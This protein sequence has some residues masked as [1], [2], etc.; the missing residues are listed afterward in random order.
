[1][2]YYKIMKKKHGKRKGTIGIILF[3]ILGIIL[4]FNIPYSKTNHEFSQLIK[5]QMEINT[6]ERDQFTIEDIRGLPEPVQKY[7]IHCGFIGTAQM[8]YMRAFYN[9]VGF[10]LNKD[11]PALKIDYTQYNFV[12]KPTRI[13]YIDS[14]MYGV[15]FE[16]EDIFINGTGE[17]KGVIA[18]TITLFDQKSEAM[19]QSSLVNCL[20]ESLMMPSIA[21]QDYIKWESIDDEHAK[22][23]ITYNGK[24]VSGIFTFNQSGEMIRFE[25][26]DRYIIETNGDSKLVKWT[27]SCGNY[28]KHNGILKPSS[29]KAAWNYSNGDEFVYFKGD[30]IIIEYY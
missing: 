15:P 6:V 16:G 30:N 1:M 14:S 10:V 27:A 12:E 29:L 2:R 25:T 23:T 22:A 9:D 18:K 3:L 21:L 11:R 24:S 4:F 7:F 13:A 26:N 20:A 19:D 8:S 28:R 5:E 17:M